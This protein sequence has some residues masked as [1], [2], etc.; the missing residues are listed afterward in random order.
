MAHR[1][2]VIDDEAPILFALRE[3][4]TLRG[5]EVDCAREPA[6]AEALIAGGTYAVIIVDLCLSGAEGTEGLGLIE[7]ARRRCPQTYIILLTA[8]GSPATEREALRRGAN[9]VLH[10][11]MPLPRMASVLAGIVER[12]RC[13]IQTG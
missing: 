7:C 1:L 3:Y 2:L 4:F 13:T 6:E 11:P 8:Y 5:Y 9:Q 10:K 12:P